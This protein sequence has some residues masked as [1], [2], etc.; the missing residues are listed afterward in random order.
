M[1]EHDEMFNPNKL[2]HN[3]CTVNNALRNQN[4]F[5]CRSKTKKKQSTEPQVERNDNIFTELL[6]L[7]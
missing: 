4:G 2:S 5:V 7:K 6:L 1:N 3:L